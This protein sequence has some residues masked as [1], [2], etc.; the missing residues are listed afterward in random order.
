M[1]SENSSKN[2]PWQLLELVQVNPDPF[3]NKGQIPLQLFKFKGTEPEDDTTLWIVAGPEGSAK[4]DSYI[5]QL[6]QKAL[7]KGTF[8]NSPDIFLTP[9]MNPQASEKSSGK[10]GAHTKNLLHGFPTATKLATGANPLEVQTL[11]RWAQYIKPKALITFSLGLPH[12]R[13]RNAP[14]ELLQKISEIAERPAYEFGTEP[15]HQAE[16]GQMVPRDN[17]ESSLGQWCVE[18]GIAWIDFSLNTS[19]KS[20]DD[21]AQVEWKTCVGPAL[22]WFVEGHRLNPPKE[23][24]LLP[25]LEVI[26]SLELP[27]EF[28]NL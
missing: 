10:N 27:P 22:K 1:T 13:Y 16:D 2:V 15:E 6:L 28:A 24:T 19:H 26:P 18:Q 4:G 25:K 9:V 7:V 17:I 23:E 21:M 3:A 5:V 20:F 11:M 8:L 12:I 14:P